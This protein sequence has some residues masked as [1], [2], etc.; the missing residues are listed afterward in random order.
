MAAAMLLAVIVPTTISA[1]FNLQQITTIT[2]NG[3]YHQLELLA[4]STAQRF[5]RLLLKRQQLAVDISQQN[6]VI[7]F[8]SDPKSAGSKL[9]QLSEIVAAHPD[10]EA[11]L[12]L[13]RTGN[14]LTATMPQFIGHH[15][16]VPEATIFSR[17]HSNVRDYPGMFVAQAVNS[18][19]IG[20]SGSVLLNNTPDRFIAIGDEG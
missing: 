3:E 17:L 16:I 14:C 10:L 2:T 8:V 18:L 19:S 12:L 13:D 5:D 11:V 6:D 15:Y 9:P 20:H 7:R 4:S 1:Y